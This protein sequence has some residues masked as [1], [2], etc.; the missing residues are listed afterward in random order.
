[1]KLRVTGRGAQSV[2][3]PVSDAV[4]A[5]P[6]HHLIRAPKVRG[7]ATVSPHIIRR[8]M[9]VRCFTSATPSPFSVAQVRS[10]TM[11]SSAVA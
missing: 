3:D 6:G 1:M 2:L 7:R 5:A 8:G 10:S 4:R 9:V 11:K